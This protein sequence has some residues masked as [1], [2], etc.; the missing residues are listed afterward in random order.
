MSVVTVQLGQCGNQIGHGLFTLLY[1]DSHTPPKY[2]SGESTENTAYKT[3]TLDKYFTELKNGTYEAK[4]VLVDMEPKVVSKYIQAAGDHG[5]AW[6]K[7][8]L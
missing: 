8:L 4:A 2:T 1:N 6:F 5:K 3:D 7:L